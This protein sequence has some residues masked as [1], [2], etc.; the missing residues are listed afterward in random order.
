VGHSWSLSVEEQFYLIWPLV[1]S[2]LSNRRAKQACWLL[3][4]AAPF[5]RWATVALF[6]IYRAFGQWEHLFHNTAD[7]L[8]V[9]CLLA[10]VLRS[11]AGQKR[12]ERLF[13]PV[14]LAAAV[15]YL[16]LSTAIQNHPPVAFV[17]YFVLSLQNV[18]LALLVAWTVLRPRTWAGTILNTGPLQ[19]IGRISY[20][21]YLWQQICLGPFWAPSGI[22]N[23]AAILVC[24]EASFWL[25]ERPCLKLRDRLFPVR[26]RTPVTA[27][28]T[29]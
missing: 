8:A 23:L 5:L 2:R 13:H 26:R 12:V 27:P 7:S 15:L 17:S 10:L 25:V 24:A 21:L 19:H 20:S 11:P 16:P 14:L 28:S 29:R 3:V 6:P 9:G 22:R 1:V 4:I 18:A